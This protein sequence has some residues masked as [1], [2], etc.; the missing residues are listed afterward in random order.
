MSNSDTGGFQPWPQNW[1]RY[2]QACYWGDDDCCDMLVGPCSCGSWHMP[3][4]FSWDGAVMIRYGKI[5][6]CCQVLSAGGG[7]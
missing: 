5:V 4:E 2:R 3:G 6:P 7:K 1:P